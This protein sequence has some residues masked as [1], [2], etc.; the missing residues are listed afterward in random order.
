MFVVKKA[1][2]PIVRCL[3]YGELALVDDCEDASPDSAEPTGVAIIGDAIDA[4]RADE[5]DPD[6]CVDRIRG[7]EQLERRRPATIYA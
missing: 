2:R 1:R 5:Q 3:E 7:L 6:E 4:Y